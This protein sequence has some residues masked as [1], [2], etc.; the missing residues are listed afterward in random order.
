MTDDDL[1][2]LCVVQ[3]AAGE[4]QQGRA[5]IARVIKNSMARKFMSDGTIS[6]T[7]LKTD[8]FSWAWFDMI[9]GRY[10]RVCSTHDEAEARAVKLLA[11]ANKAT[12][13]TCRDI[14]H[15]VMAGTYHGDLYD[16]LTDDAVNY[17]NPAISSTAWATPAKLV[18]VIGHHNFYRA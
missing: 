4:V 13:E 17:L 16:H 15:Q 8:Q 18:C 3:E 7:I 6:G 9:D 14:A 12:L 10:T 2:A 5:A 1:L 11:S